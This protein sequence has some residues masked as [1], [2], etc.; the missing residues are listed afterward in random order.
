MGN[1]VGDGWEAV[2]NGR[3]GIS[4]I[5]EMDVS[6]LTTQIAGEIKNFEVTDYLSA[7]EARRYDRFLQYGLAAAQE[8][9][10]SAGLAG[11]DHGID[12][13][14]AGFLTIGNE[15]KDFGQSKTTYISL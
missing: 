8:A 6:G 11:E 9:L 15:L 7:K 14:R 12:P 3:S 2:C 13:E 1:T 5:T 10:G 4:R